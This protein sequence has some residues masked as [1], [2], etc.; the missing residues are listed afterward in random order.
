ML[1]WP[2][3]TKKKTGHCGLSHVGCDTLLP[4]CLPI[5]TAF[6][7]RTWGTSRNCWESTALLRKDTARNRNALRRGRC[8]RHASLASKKIFHVLWWHYLVPKQ[9]SGKLICSRQQQM[10]VERHLYIYLYKGEKRNKHSSY[11]TFFNSYSYFLVCTSN[12]FIWYVFPSCFK[13][14]KKE[15]KSVIQICDAPSLVKLVKLNH[16]SSALLTLWRQFKS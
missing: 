8:C 4:K 14:R 12:T 9:K 7:R 2:A 6:P 16:Q 5:P 3:W 10:Q 1:G 15:K 11:E 13:K